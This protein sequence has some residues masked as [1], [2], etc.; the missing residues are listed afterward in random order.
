M[1]LDLLQSNIDIFSHGVL[2]LK[3]LNDKLCLSFLAL[4]YHFLFFDSLHKLHL[5]FFIFAVS[6]TVWSLQS[7]IWPV[8][9]SLSLCSCNATIAKFREKWRYISWGGV[10]GWQLLRGLVLNF[11]FVLVWWYYYLNCWVHPCIRNF[12]LGFNLGIIRCNH[13]SSFEAQS[14]NWWWFDFIYCF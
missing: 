7:Q 3:E 14:Y 2:L 6:A 1:R 11:Q 4:R 13:T 12:W 10:N 8:S 9:C 5:S